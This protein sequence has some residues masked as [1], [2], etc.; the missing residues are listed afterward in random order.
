MNILKIMGLKKKFG[1]FKAVDGVNLKMYSGQIFALLGHNGAGKSTTISMLTGLIPP[2]AGKCQVFDK[3]LFSQM[4]EVRK[5][6]GVCPQHDV[7]FD[8]L[9]PEEHLDVFC[10]F[11]GVR[12]KDKKADIKRVLEDIDLYPQRNQ[13]AQSLSGG[14]RRKLSV[15]IALVGGSKFILLDEPTAGMD[16]SAR[17][18]MWDMLK[19]YKHD[20]I[21]SLTTH[22]MDEADILGDRIGI[23][24]HGRIMCLGRSMFLKNKFGVGYRLSMVKKTKEPNTLVESFLRET[25]GDEVTRLGEVSSEI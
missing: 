18:K 25:L 16:L 10:D 14:Q 23:M 5:N 22:Y 17:R 7:L 19:K 12:V 6:M 13:R 24:A 11:K 3:D 15:A 21:I 4:D 8:L 9:T 1:D 20:R 2:T